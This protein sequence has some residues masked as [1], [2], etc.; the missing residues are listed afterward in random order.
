[1]DVTTRDDVKPLRTVAI[2]P[3]FS[4]IAICIS[5]RS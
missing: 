2:V 3:R 1:V 4:Q 5:G